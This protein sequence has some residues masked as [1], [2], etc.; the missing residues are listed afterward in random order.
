[1]AISVTATVVTLSYTATQAQLTK[2]LNNAA[3]RLYS[4]FPIY[5][6]GDP[7]TLVPF[8]SLTNAQKLGVID[9]FVRQV[10]IASA[11]ANADALALAV[12]QNDDQSLT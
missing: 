3:Q 5:T 6:P 4:D 9:Q 11:R 12:A 10:I 8:A 1:M 2:V 7:S